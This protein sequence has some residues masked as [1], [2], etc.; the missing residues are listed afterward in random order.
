MKEKMRKA[1]EN[2]E[3]CKQKGRQGRED[4][5]LFSWDRGGLALKEA[6]EAV[7]SNRI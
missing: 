7:I 3:L 2:P 4:M 1:Y 5:R 6:I